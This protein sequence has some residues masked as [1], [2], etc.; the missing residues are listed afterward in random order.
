MA[1]V[2]DPVAIDTAAFQA[3]AAFHALRP[4]CTALALRTAA[5]QAA[6]TAV[7]TDAI[8]G[9]CGGHFPSIGERAFFTCRYADEFVRGFNLASR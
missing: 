4:Q 7:P 2:V 5:Y 6:D 8:R 1:T 3:G 9:C